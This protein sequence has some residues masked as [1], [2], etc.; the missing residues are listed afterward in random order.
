MV[1]ISLPKTECM[2]LNIVVGLSGVGKSTVL[3]EA[4]LLSDREYELVN[5]G[6]KMMETAKEHG[7][8][9]DQ[10]K[11]LDVAT[12]KEIQAEAAEKIFK[13]AEKHNVLVD[14]H[15]AIKTPHG[16]VPGLPQWSIEEMNPDK[17][18]MLTASAEDI[19]ERT[20]GD[21]RDREHESVEDIMEYQEIA[22][23][24][25]STNAVMTGAYLK[26]IENRDG[27]AEK[28]AE[29]LVKALKA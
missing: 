21:D 28:A 12:Y 9:R 27:Q 16:Y 29:E 6:D 17:I 7:V 23:E 13:L 18:I 2:S 3:E 22:R 25:A 24:M 15:S 20:Q 5:Y 10:M 8:N 4:V 14:T 1:K 26:I 11:E 19:W